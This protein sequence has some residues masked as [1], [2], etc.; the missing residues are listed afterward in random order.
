MTTRNEQLS[1][2]I[3]ELSDQDLLRGDPEDL[4]QHAQADQYF[5]DGFH[6]LPYV[7]QNDKNNIN[8]ALLQ[9]RDFILIIFPGSKMIQNWTSHTGNFSFRRVR[10]LGGKIHKGFW[11]QV[12]SHWSELTN[13]LST[14]E[15][16]PLV[17]GG[18]SRGGACALIA[19][20][21]VE[22]EFGF[23]R[24]GAV[25][26]LGQPGCVNFKLARRINRDWG[27]RYVRVVTSTDVIPLAP[28]WPWYYHGGKVWFCKKNSTRLVNPNKDQIEQAVREDN[29]LMHT[30]RN[31][32][33]FFLSIQR[34]AQRIREGHDLTT[35][36]DCLNGPAPIRNG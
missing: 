18:H 24:I 27:D 6:S 19:A 23:D 32:L 1:V 21:R 17:L 7:S 10:R 12:D 22:H 25:I 16:L 20:L 5:G 33:M 4:L 30:Q 3:A 8:F 36:C 14:C 2:L 28:T 35:Y 13:K 31:L 34:Q 29:P 26:T 9:H 15:S 11:R